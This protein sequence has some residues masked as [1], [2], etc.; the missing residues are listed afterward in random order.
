MIFRGMADQILYVW[1][2]W[3]HTLGRQSCF[4]WQYYSYPGCLA[5]KTERNVAP[6][7]LYV[8]SV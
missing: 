8:I 2:L 1:G 4:V 7:D 5:T 6:R 3:K